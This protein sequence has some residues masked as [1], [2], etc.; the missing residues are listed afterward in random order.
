MI[1]DR[2][3]AL[4][5]RPLANYY[6]I[7]SIVGLLVLSGVLMVVASSMTWSLAEG[8]GVW[9]SALKQMVMVVIGLASMWLMLWLPPGV[10]RR[11]STLAM[12]FTVVLLVV[13][14][15]PGF[16]TGREEVGSQSWIVLGPCGC[17]PQRS[18]V[19]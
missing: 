12:A 1:G 14:L 15:I 3:S 17:S 8:S 11:F 18:L 13:V 2:I 10:V 16:G 4:F 7:L 9:G 6:I 5:Q 19:S